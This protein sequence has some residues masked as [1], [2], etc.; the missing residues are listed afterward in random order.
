MNAGLALRGCSVLLMIGI[1]VGAP[2][3]A[4][5]AGAP[6]DRSALQRFEE[7]TL[8]YARLRRI[9]DAHL[10]PIDAASDPDAIFQFF[11][12]LSA[13]MQAARP[14]ARP[15]DL[16]TPIVGVVIRARIAGALAAHGID[17]GDLRAEIAE[18]PA[19]T[20]RM[21]VNGPY[22]WSAPAAMV[23]CLIE[24]LPALPAELQYRFVG[25][26]LFLIDVDAGLVVDILP[27]AVPADGSSIPRP[28]L[29]GDAS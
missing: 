25:D 24:V 7:A 28:A 3:E 21:Q 16:F 26:D 8:E 11:T 4:Q 29:D 18:G 10:A 17:P 15:G 2:V 14:A 9:V 23:G 20:A 12:A 22:D 5:P 27:H 19:A 1:F 6:S 13:G